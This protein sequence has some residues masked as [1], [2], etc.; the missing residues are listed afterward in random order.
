MSLLT[1]KTTICGK[2]STIWP[3]KETNLWNSD[4]QGKSRCTTSGNLLECKK[5]PIFTTST[6]YRFIGPPTVFLNKGKIIPLTW[7]VWW[8]V[9]RGDRSYRYIL[10]CGL[11]L[12]TLATVC[13]TWSP[14]YVNY[15]CTQEVD[16]VCFRVICRAVVISPRLVAI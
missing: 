14:Y 8:Q 12:E 16:L 4:G 2:K 11:D 7:T 6:T 9:F 13:V 15:K 3:T 5:K 1:W 10:A